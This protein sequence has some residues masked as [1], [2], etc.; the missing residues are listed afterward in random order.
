MTDPELRPLTV[1]LVE[2]DAGDARL[3]AELLG[4]SA[5]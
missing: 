2:D 3:I 1:L 5:G 4:R